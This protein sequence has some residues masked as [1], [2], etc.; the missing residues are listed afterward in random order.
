MNVRATMRAWFAAV[1][2]AA[3]CLPALP[4]LAE[5][6]TLSTELSG[7]QQAWDQANYR[8][9]NA[10][11]KQRRLEE[12]ATRSEALARRYPSQ[13]EPLVWHVPWIKEFA[14]NV[15]RRLALDLLMPFDTSD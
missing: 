15:I 8:S 6:S 5:D 3:A 2:V 14:L 4:V 12:L 11:D 10:E 9:A 1:A 7:I 13:A